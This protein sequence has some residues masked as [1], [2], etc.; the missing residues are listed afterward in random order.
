MNER[1]EISDHANEQAELRGATQD[2][3]REA[4]RTGEEVPAKKGRTG[5]R[6]TFQYGAAWREVYYENKQVLAIV[7]RENETVI[8]ITVFA[9]YF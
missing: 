9:F 4:I 7:V 1:I 8:V 3:V 5:Y 6:K 2:E